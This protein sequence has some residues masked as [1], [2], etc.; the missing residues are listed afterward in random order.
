MCTHHIHMEVGAR[1]TE[2]KSGNHLA[3]ELRSSVGKPSGSFVPD[4]GKI[5]YVSSQVAT[6]TSFSHAEW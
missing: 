1:E 5:A 6:T 4:S 2:I 3:L